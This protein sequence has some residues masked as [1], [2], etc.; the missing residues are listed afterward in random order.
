MLLCVPMSRMSTWRH[1]LTQAQA[2]QQSSQTAQLQEPAL[3]KIPD[4]LRSLIAG[5]E[6]GEHLEKVIVQTIAPPTAATGRI[7]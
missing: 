5:G 7:I 3:S 6:N 4:D 1:A 2:Q